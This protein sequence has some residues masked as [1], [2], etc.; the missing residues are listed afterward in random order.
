MVGFL[1]SLILFAGSALLRACNGRLEGSNVEI[2]IE[3]GF[4]PG[5][6]CLPLILSRKSLPTRAAAII[7]EIRAR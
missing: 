3:K 7:D 5:T 4:L 6:L 2:E 1:S